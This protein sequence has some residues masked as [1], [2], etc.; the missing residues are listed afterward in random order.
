M[1]ME[2]FLFE[3]LLFGVII[4]ISHRA[5]LSKER[6]DKMMQYWLNGVMRDAEQRRERVGR[7][8]LKLVVNNKQRAND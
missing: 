6:Q 5:R 2:I 8:H 7:H 4:F 1:V 3:L